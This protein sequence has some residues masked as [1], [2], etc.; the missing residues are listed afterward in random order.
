LLADGLTATNDYLL[1]LNGGIV[2]T[3]SADANGQLRIDSPLAVPTE[4]LDLHSVALWDSASNV[5]LSTT[6]P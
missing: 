5:V 4:I 3:N 2:Q 6:L 1:V